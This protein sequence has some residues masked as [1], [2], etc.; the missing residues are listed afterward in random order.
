MRVFDW[1]YEG[2][3]ADPA[4]RKRFV[5]LQHDV[6]LPSFRHSALKMAVAVGL[7]VALVVIGW[8]LLLAGL[9][10]VASDDALATWLLTAILLAAGQV[11]LAL[12]CWRYAATVWSH[13]REPARNDD[14]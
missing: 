1:L 10:Y 8:G 11:M 13:P 7:C 2:I 4:G 6:R 14:R 5:E 3:A 12:V 9:L